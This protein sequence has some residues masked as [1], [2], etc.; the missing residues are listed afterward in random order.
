VTRIVV[1]GQALNRAAGTGPHFK[2][3][4]ARWARRVAI[5]GTIGRKLARLSGLEFHEWMRRTE[6]LNLINRWPGRDGIFGD[7]FP[8]KEAVA[9]A[10]RLHPRLHGRMVILLGRNVADAFT[11]TDLRELRWCAFGCEE[12]EW[13]MAIV[14]HPSGLNRWW[15]DAVNQRKAGRFLLKAYREVKP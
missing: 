9:N 11:L 3:W 15:N 4:G 7:A 8:M 12:L 2:R 1:I 5:T 14:P 10:Y 6:R 13:T